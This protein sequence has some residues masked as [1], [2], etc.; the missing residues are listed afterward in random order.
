MHMHVASSKMGGL[1]LSVKVGSDC[2]VPFESN[3]FQEE[4]FG[5]LLSRLGEDKSREKEENNWSCDFF[6]FFTGHP[7]LLCD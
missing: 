2:S 4:T 7:G 1:G 6:F 3:C 5:D